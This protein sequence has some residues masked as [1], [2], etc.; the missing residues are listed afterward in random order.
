MSTLCGFDTGCEAWPAPRAV[1][2]ARP[3]PQP[4]L[5]PSRQDEVVHNVRV[6]RAYVTQVRSWARSWFGSARARRDAAVRHLPQYSRAESRNRSHKFCWC[7]RPLLLARVRIC[8]RADGS[9]ETAR[10]KP[11]T[12][13]LRRKH[14]CRAHHNVTC[15]IAF[16]PAR[17][18]EPL[19]VRARCTLVRLACVATSAS[20]LQRAR[21]FT[22]A[23]R[24]CGS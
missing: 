22:T 13:P 15:S 10:P 21:F 18:A 23:R 7:S 4:S 24:V 1:C 3:G 14:I 12:R 8:E 20:R 2:H 16:S 17:C 19:V 11:G 6:C 5:G 9:A